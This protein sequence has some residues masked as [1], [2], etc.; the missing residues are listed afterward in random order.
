MSVVVGG[1]EATRGLSL[2]R[3]YG[4]ITTSSNHS[5]I[6][7]LSDMVAL[8]G[9]RPSFLLPTVQQAPNDIRTTKLKIKPRNGTTAAWLEEIYDLLSQYRCSKILSEATPPSR[10]AF[11]EWAVLHIDHSTIDQAYSQAIQQWWDE[12]TLVY[13]IVR[14]SIDLSGSFESAD[15]QF[16]REQFAVGDYRNGH[17]LFTWAT[18]FSNTSSIA[19]QAELTEKVIN[20][21]IV[22]TPNLSQL[23]QHLSS[24]FLNWT[25]ICGNSIAEPAPLYHHLLRSLS[26]GGQGSKLA[27]LYSWVAERVT[28]DDPILKDPAAFFERISKHARNLQFPATGQS[29]QMGLF[30]VGPDGKRLYNRCNF[31]PS[32]LCQSKNNGNTKEKC[33][34]FNRKLAIPNNA[35]AGE[36]SFLNQ[37]RDY[38][39]EI[40]PATLKGL[41]GAQI[42]AKEKPTVNAVQPPDNTGQGGLA[43][44]AAPP[45]APTPAQISVVGAGLQSTSQISDR[46][47]F[48][49]YMA[50]LDQPGVIMISDTPTET[51]NLS[52]N[53]SRK[54]SLDHAPLSTDPSVPWIS[55][56]E[57]EALARGFNLPISLIA[58]REQFNKFISSAD[59]H[60]VNMI[61][62]GTP[63]SPI[64]EDASENEDQISELTQASRAPSKCQI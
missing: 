38:A 13:H 59:R 31:C 16:L 14:G 58:D 5:R 40:K 44:A 33:L 12:N 51:E 23:E 56:S 46:E 47:Q 48:E 9:S 20:S 36:K 54:R 35:S 3:P 57:I 39:D 26:S 50:S 22:A 43:P 42:K 11:T 53:N 21:K 29:V 37:C 28:D 1:G 34:S 52:S 27:H 6:P 10:E 4:E 55:Q 62:A 30:A 49:Q 24:L 8:P 64:I 19:S 32:N 18:S 41:K 2:D 63:C 25:K 15:L 17:G 61:S 45:A 60:S 7:V